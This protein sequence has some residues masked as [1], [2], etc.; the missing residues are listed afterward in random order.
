MLVVVTPAKNEQ[1]TLPMVAKSIL[2]QTHRPKFWLIVD[3]CSTDKTP[4]IIKKLENK[5]AWIKCLSTKSECSY[6]SIERYG[7]ILR[8]G[9]SYT[10]NVCHLNKL[11]CEFLAVLDADT[12]LDENY[13][14]VLIDA[15][16]NE[17][18]LGIASG[19]Y[20][21]KHGDDL[22]APKSADGEYLTCGAAMV[23]REACYKEIGGF[24]ILPRSDT[25]A[26]IKAIN[27]GWKVKA[28]RST[29]TI[30][31]RPRTA[32]PKLWQEYVKRGAVD[33]KLNYHPINTFLSGIYIFVKSSP[34]EGLSYLTG[35]SKSF[36]LKEKK[37][38]DEEIKEYFWGSFNRLLMRTL[39]K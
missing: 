37:I 2:Q 8:K 6:D 39:K 20:I 35:Y 3:D 38:D 11:K 30:H 34:S 21:E 1:Q 9:F 4:Q 18:T 22:Y 15:F 17:P 26:K 12:I 10:A 24:P 23:F 5:Y 31:T 33:Y 29:N 28:I 19:I 16:H 27:R 13:Y 25:V 32:K 36:L 7:Y 14:E